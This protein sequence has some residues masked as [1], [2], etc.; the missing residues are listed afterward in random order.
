MEFFLHRLFP[1]RSQNFVSVSSPESIRHFSGPTLSSKS[2]P[3]A[4]WMQRGSPG[5]VSA[6]LNIIH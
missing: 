1:V 6:Y 2:R 3:V 4:P 5:F